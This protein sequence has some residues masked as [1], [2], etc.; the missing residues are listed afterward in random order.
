MKLTLIPLLAAAATASPLAN[1]SPAPAAAEAFDLAV[2]KR[3]GQIQPT[4]CTVGYQYCGWALLDGGIGMFFPSIAPLL[5]PQVLA[6][7]DWWTGV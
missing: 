5:P 6:T 3:A 7:V 1:T 4:P 2:L